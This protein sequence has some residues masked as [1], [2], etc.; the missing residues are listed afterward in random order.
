MQFGAGRR[1]DDAS[2]D[3]DNESIVAAC[4]KQAVGTV[5]NAKPADPWRGSEMVCTGVGASGV[6]GDVEDTASKGC[7]YAEVVNGPDGRAMAESYKRWWSYANNWTV[8]D[9]WKKALFPVIMRIVTWGGARVTM[10]G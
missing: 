3:G 8:E 6:E 9:E 5:I 10:G 2:V 1:P 4:R 7:G